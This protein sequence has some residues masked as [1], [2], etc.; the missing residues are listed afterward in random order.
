MNGPGIPSTP[1]RVLDAWIALHSRQY[2]L[3]AAQRAQFLRHRA[4]PAICEYPFADVYTCLAR[5]QKLDAVLNALRSGEGTPI[6]QQSESIG[7]DTSPAQ[8]GKGLG[9]QFARNEAKGTKEAAGPPGSPTTGPRAPVDHRTRGSG[10][11]D[12]VNKPPV[13]SRDEARNATP[14][15]DSQ[16]RP[17]YN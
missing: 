4:L 12:L 5:H 9:K 6:P 17:D 11:K 13:I 3:S 1:Q 8:S 14:D 2:A 10:T 15:F 7:S 16:N